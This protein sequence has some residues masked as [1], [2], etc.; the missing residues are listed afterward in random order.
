MIVTN[1]ANVRCA[2][3]FYALVEKKRIGALEAAWA[4][5]RVGKKTAEMKFSTQHTVRVLV[6]R[7]NFRKIPKTFFEQ[8]CAGLRPRLFRP[9]AARAVRWIRSSPTWKR[10]VN[11]RN[12]VQTEAQNRPVVARRR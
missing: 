3:C 7:A 10:V 2:V 12:H 9:A 5:R 6:A 11:R 4:G 8:P 1:L